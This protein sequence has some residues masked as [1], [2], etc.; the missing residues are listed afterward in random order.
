MNTVTNPEEYP[1]HGEF[2]YVGKE[3]CRR[4]A[5][6][7]KRFPLFVFVLVAIVGL[8]GL[9]IWVELV[10]ALLSE[11]PE[12]SDGLFTAVATFYPALAGSA[13]CQLILNATGMLNRIITALGI[14]VLFIFLAAAVL[15]GIFH[16]QYP[17][18]CLISAI[19]LVVFS[20]W[21]WI[22]SNADNPIFHPV[23]IDAAS[24]GSPSRNPKGDLSGF[25][26]D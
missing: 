25:K 1:D 23:R 10:K 21:I 3:L 26:A 2:S 4:T 8:G 17:F 19:I 15:V 7:W 6:I 9:G 16:S 20:I 5:E 11:S 12:E 18:A 14:L 22:I 13:S 24:G